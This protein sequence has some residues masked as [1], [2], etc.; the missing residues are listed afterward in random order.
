MPEP[1]LTPT[2]FIVLGLI[3][4]AGEATPY[5]LKQQVAATIGNFWSVPHAQLYNEP[6]RLAAAG[7]LTEKIEK[8]GRRRKRYRLTKAG[9]EALQ[10]WLD[11]P[12]SDFTELRDPGLLQ[13]FLGAELRP[14]ADAQ[15]EVHG[16][17]LKEYSR[18]RAAVADHLPER[19]RLVLDSGIGHEREWVRFWKNVLAGS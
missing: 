11:A 17:R 8:T 15:L 13:L 5:E 2:S 7:L 18:L 9:K 16:A 1:R 4:Q 6:E 19:M 3:S 10:A 14:L 12:T